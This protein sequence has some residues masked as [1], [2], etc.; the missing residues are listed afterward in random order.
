M[1]TGQPLPSQQYGPRALALVTHE[2]GVRA[3]CLDFEERH[4]V[5]VLGPFPGCFEPHL[6]HKP[7]G[8]D[9]IDLVQVALEG[10]IPSHDANVLHHCFACS[11]DM[12]P[13]ATS[14]PTGMYP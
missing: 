14:A 1:L 6:V 2:F 10:V 13:F 9:L 3:V 12:V 11:M 7:S 4:M 5:A 8:T